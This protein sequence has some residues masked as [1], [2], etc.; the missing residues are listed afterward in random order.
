MAPEWV[1][2]L[3]I[4]SKVD[5]Y[6]YGIVVMEMIT[7]KSPQELVNVD[8]GMEQKMDLVREMMDREEFDDDDGK[9]E[10]LM[11]VALQCAQE[12]KEARPTMRQV[13]H[14]LLDQET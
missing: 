9:M 6:S 4:T 11:R 3:P 13:I 7:G 10:N 1:L 14:M 8:G 12:N 2:N 5:V